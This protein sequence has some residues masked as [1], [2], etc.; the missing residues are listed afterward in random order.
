MD[1]LVSSNLE[2]FLF[3]VGGRD[4]GPA[5]TWSRLLAESGAFTVDNDTRERM[6]RLIV[7]GWAGEAEVLATIGEEFRRTGYVLDTHTAVAVAVAG[8]RVA[9]DGLHTIIASTASPYK[10]GTRVLQG[11]TGEVVE[12]EFRAIDRISALSGLPVHRAL[13]GLRQRPERHTRVIEKNRMQET[14]L[15]L[16]REIA[17]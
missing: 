2:R 15:E 16:M 1:I 11:L 17:G 6:D 14:L 7:S 3:E 13:V 4:A 12:D 5:A 10:F 8:R 9:R